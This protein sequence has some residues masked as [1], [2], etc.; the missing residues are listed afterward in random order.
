MEPLY[1]IRPQKVSDSDRQVD[2]DVPIAISPVKNRAD[3][4]SAA[5]NRDGP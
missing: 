4:E 1:Y 5:A 2:R 3:P